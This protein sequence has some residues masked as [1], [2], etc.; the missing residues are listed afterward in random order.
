MAEESRKD[1][2][3]YSPSKSPETAEHAEEKQSQPDMRLHPGGTH[4]T[5]M[6][7]GMEGL[8]RDD[9][10]SQANRSEQ[11]QMGERIKP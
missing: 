11:L 10:P 1:T 5:P 4:G 3:A 6:P 7:T 8:S 2:G 9:V